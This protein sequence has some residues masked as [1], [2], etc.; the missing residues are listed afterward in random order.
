MDVKI[1]RATAS[2]AQG[3][4]DVVNSVIQ[5]GGLT[6]LYPTLT[7]EQETEFIQGLGPRSAMFVA[8]TSGAILGMQTV[9]PWAPYTRSMD[10]V[11]ELGTFV[12]RNFRR[13]GVGRALMEKTLEFCRVQGYEKIVIQ[14]RAG[15]AN[16]QAFYRK[17]GFVPKMLLERQ[18]KIEGKY[19]DQ[20]WMEMFLP[21][22]ETPAAAEKA[23]KAAPAKVPQP[24]PVVAAA[25][26]VDPV[27]GAVTVRRAGRQDVR[28]LTA[29]M[30]GTMRW[31][32]APAEEEVLEMLFDKGYWLAISR[33]GGGL[34]GWRAENLVMCID[35]FY[36]YPPQ[37]HAQVGGPL[38]ETIETE[39]KALSCEVAI[40]FLDKRIAPEALEFFASRGYEPQEMDKLFSVW[41]E[42]AQ[43]FLTGDRLMLVKKLREK[44]I[45]RPI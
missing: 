5:E 37:F 39:A 45:M 33:K 3:V 12:Y 31:R 18:V 15:N 23:A 26:T 4:V 10:H 29:I 6:A 43:E 40:A 36:V 20:V 16:A 32:P 11:A 38:L 41:R 17:M 35:D 30:K 24:E 13:R 1:H 27:V 21:V 28:M 14:V 22:A 8:E 2:D 25:P 42:V 44:R 9:S 7:V 19:D 34:S